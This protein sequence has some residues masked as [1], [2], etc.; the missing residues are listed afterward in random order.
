MP[1]RLCFNYSMMW[2]AGSAWSG[3]HDANSGVIAVARLN[4]L[5]P[6][7]DPFPLDDLFL[8]ALIPI[9]THAKSNSRRTPGRLS[10]TP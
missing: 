1:H 6:N 10:H 7:S 2:L 3:N 5:T 8:L 4:S 9:L